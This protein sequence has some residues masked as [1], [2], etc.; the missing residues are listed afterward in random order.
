[1]PRETGHA[2]A[3]RRARRERP[4]S[5]RRS[6]APDQLPPCVGCDFAGQCLLALGH[7]DAEAGS[8]HEVVRRTWSCAAGDVVIRRGDALR[9]VHVVRTG[10][11]KVF[12]VASDGREQVLGFHLPGELV[13]LA[14]IHLGSHPGDVVA[15]ESTQFCG[16]SFEDVLNV[17]SH[18][19]RVQQ[20][21]LRLMSGELGRASQLAGDLN[22]EERVASFLLDLQRR[23]SHHRNN[24]RPLR[25]TMSRTD[26]A[27]YLRL[28]AETVSRVFSRFR[29]RGWLDVTGRNVRLLDAEALHRV[30]RNSP[31][32]GS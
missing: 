17:S 1:M 15:L 29:A 28:A 26:M 3:S 22:A 20:Q 7:H 14:A 18:E 5:Q 24:D 13:G 2:P 4:R 19:P 8:H 25:L 23:G 16:L 27:N 12:V 31:G 11:V 30:C 21:L 10:G 32:A 6:A 9:E